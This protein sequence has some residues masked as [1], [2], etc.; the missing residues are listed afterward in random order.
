MDE[1]YYLYALTWAD[2]PPQ[3][4]QAGVDPRFPVE[5]WPAGRVAGIVSRVGLDQFRIDKLQ[6]DTT[7]VAW[8]GEVAMRHNGIVAALARRG[9][10]LP[11]KLGTLFQSRSSLADKLAKCEAEV[12]AFLRRLADRQEWAVKVYF[13]DTR[14]EEVLVPDDSSDR[15]LLKNHRG[16]A[17]SAG[18][19]AQYLAARQRQTARRRNVQVAVKQELLALDQRLQPLVDDWRALPVLPGTLTGR[20]EKMV[21]NGAFLVAGG[22]QSLFHAACDDLRHHLGGKGLLLE[23][24]GPWPLYHF[25]P[26]LD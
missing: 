5:I 24:T 13:D 11:L 1:P 15:D 23:V 19:G 7:D 22:G 14:A 8:L 4:P 12:A 10:V 20:R 26:M 6:A 18:A 17:T 3:P 25:C 2:V 21:W 16:M 9:T